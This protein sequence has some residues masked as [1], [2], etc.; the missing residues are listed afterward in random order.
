MSYTAYPLSWPLGKPR[1]K[2]QTPAAFSTSLA[3]ARDGL[4]LELERMSARN[5]VLSTN[6][7]LRRDGLPYAGRP[8]PRDTGVA[9]YFTWRSEQYAFA[10]DCWVKVEDNLQ[11]IRKTVEAIRG[12]ARWG[13]GEMV[14]AAFAGFRALPEQATSASWWQV[15]GV[16]E[17]ASVAEIAAAFRAKA[18]TAHPDV[19]TGSE[20]QMQLLNAAREQ[21]LANKMS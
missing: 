10:C 21:G 14:N 2:V 18:K 20:E 3:Q 6:V 16:S 1:T 8:Q 13:T 12:I 7:E 4:L 11:A 15:L 5:I 19:A 17:T 9:V